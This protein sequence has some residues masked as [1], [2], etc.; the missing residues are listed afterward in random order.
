[1]HLLGY[2][3]RTSNNI[4]VV[5]VMEMG[6]ISSNHHELPYGKWVRII[7]VK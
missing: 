4:V 7:E 3:L 5:V 2:P 6:N 1:M